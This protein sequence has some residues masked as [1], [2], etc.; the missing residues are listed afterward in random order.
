MKEKA[1]QEYY[2]EDFSHCYGCGTKNEFGHQLKTYWEGKETISKF[3]PK[4]EHTALPGF[5]YGGLIAS[6]I[7]CHSTGSGSAALYKAQKEKS[8]NYPRCV[9]ASLDVEYLKPTPIDCTLI[10]KGI[11]AEI[12]GRKVRIETQLL[13]DNVVCAIGNVLVIQVPDNWEASK[14][15]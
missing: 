2:T 7:D 3:T 15:S 8:K 13:A 12:S 5:V 11:I 9:T 4:P 1:F 10:L 6:L 14:S